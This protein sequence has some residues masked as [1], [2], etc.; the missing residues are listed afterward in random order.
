MPRLARLP[1]PEFPHDRVQGRKTQDILRIDGVGVAAQRLDAGDAER[2]GAKFGGRT[3]LRSLDGSD[4]VGLVERAGESKIGLAA[5][6]GRSNRL[7][8]GARRRDDALEKARGDGRLRSAFPG[9]AE[10]RLLG[11]ERGDEI[12]RGL[13]DAPL[14]R[15]K[16]ELERASAG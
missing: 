5:L 1:G 2:T 6:L 14:R 16:A 15:R 4:G 13:T 3:G 8:A 10:N 11:A 7:G 9:A 12:M